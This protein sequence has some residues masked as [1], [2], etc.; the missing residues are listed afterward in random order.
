MVCDE[1]MNIQV[2]A[3]LKESYRITVDFFLTERALLTSK[4]SS[5]LQSNCRGDVINAHA[6]NERN[7]EHCSDLKCTFVVQVLR[8]GFLIRVT[9]RTSNIFGLRPGYSTTVLAT[10]P[11]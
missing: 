11:S 5:L 2:Q 4:H 9:D 6:Q 8:L 3:S 10:F 7:Y 1:E